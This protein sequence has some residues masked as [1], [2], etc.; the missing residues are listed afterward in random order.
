VVLALAGLLVRLPET[1]GALPAGFVIVSFL[2]PT[3]AYALVLPAAMIGWR[4]LRAGA[5]SMAGI[6][7]AFLAAFGVQSISDAKL[8]FA[9]QEGALRV[10]VRCVTPLGAETAS[11][12]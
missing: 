6:T 12:S 8:S 9:P 3:L 7:V 10:N 1:V 11:T 2:V 5:R 4:D